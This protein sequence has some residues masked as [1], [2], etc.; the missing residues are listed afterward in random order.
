MRRW[1]RGLTLIEIAV[2]MAVLAILAS[3]GVPMFQERVARQRLITTAE[4]LAQDLADARFEAAQSGQTLHIVF[5]TGSDWCYAVSRSA[6]CSC[7]GA[8]ACQVKVVRAA[9]APGVS[10]P[11]AEN[12]SFDPAA[13]ESGGGHALL[14]GVGG[15]QQLRVGL[16]LLGRPRVCTSTSL[17]GYPVC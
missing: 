11:K 7:H 6:A 9:D 3:I 10:L 2:A 16:T 1:I 14:E 5:S 17:T 12:L 13:V 8:D 4:M 15:A